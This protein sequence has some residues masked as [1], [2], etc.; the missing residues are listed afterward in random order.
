M[1]RGPTRRFGPAAREIVCRVAKTSPQQWGLPFT[2]WSLSKLVEHLGAYHRV[3]ISAET[4]RRS[5]ARLGS[6][7]YFDLK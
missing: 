3:V 1:E 6:A 4:G 7:S 2:T 5:C